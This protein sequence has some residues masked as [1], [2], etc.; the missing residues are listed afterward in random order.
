MP[1]TH[2]SWLRRLER[3]VDPAFDEVLQRILERRQALERLLQQLQEQRL[4][5]FPQEPWPGVMK[6]YS[7]KSAN[8]RAGE[9][10]LHRAS[11]QGHT[12][13]VEVLLRAGADVAA[14]SSNGWTAL[15][16]ASEKGHT[17]VVAALLRAGADV[18][19][20][21]NSG[22]TALHKASIGGHTEVVAALLRAGADVAAKD[23]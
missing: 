8:R 9:T 10:A 23:K 14:K 7:K 3:L 16:W 1:K 18:A 13:V 15:H 11:N 17:E 2:T 12:E 22:F 19:A 6:S 20:K 5:I 21:T 4:V